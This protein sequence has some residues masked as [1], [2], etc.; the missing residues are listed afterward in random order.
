VATGVGALE[1]GGDAGVEGDLPPEDAEDQ[2]VGE[3][4]VGLGEGGHARAVEEV[5]GVGR[6]VGYAEEDGEGGGTGGSDGGV[7]RSLGLWR[8]LGWRGFVC[9]VSHRRLGAAEVRGW[10]F[11][12]VGTGG[13]VEYVDEFGRS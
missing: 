12:H 8:S 5:V 1:E 6:G 2:G 7:G 3:V 13:T 4:A 9:R 10:G 11:G